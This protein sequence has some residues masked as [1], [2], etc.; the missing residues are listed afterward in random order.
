M[1][2]VED[3]EIIAI[4]AVYA[5]LKGLDAAAQQRVIEYVGKKLGI[6]PTL[7]GETA[8]DFL[9]DRREK[10]DPLASSGAKGP[11]IDADEDL[12]AI[13]PIAKKWMRRNGLTAK[14][15]S[16]VF[17]IGGDEIDLIAKK[18]PGKSV[19]ARMRSVFLLEGVAAYLAGG[20]ARFSHEKVK[21]AC[22][23][24]DAYD[25]RNFATY[26]RELAAEVS[27][28][29]ESGYTLTARGLANATEIVRELAGATTAG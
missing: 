23:H 1:K 4:G 5:S 18:V 12:D 19:R 29:K 13:S 3:K 2:S 8:D 20:A 26:L 7:P 25:V 27:G 17:S 9:E 28:G 15:L 10:A 21:E 11:T 14:D 6:T 24:Y 16:K 22:L